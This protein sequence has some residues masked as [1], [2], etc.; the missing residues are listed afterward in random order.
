MIRR[1]FQVAV[2]ATVNAS[3]FATAQI[4]P[5]VFGY[6]WHVTKM[7]TN[8]NSLDRCSLK[9]YRNSNIAGNLLDSSSIANADVSD[10]EFD[11]ACLEKL[12]FEWQGATPNSVATAIVYGMQESVW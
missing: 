6:Q 5:T 12:I 7:V 8:V 10:T 9:V 1:P 11:L 4:G 3:R 2:N